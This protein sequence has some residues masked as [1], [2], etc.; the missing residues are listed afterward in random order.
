LTQRAAI[1]G[2]WLG[3]VRSMPGLAH[4]G[5]DAAHQPA[6]PGP[7]APRGAPRPAAPP[8][9]PPPARRRAP[10]PPRRSAGT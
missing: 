9:P 1:I 10:R 7:R 2:E 5:A 4:R 3:R 8:P 6:G